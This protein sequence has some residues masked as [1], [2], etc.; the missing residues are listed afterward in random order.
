MI[1]TETH[2]QVTETDLQA[3]N[4]LTL[5][6]YA[7][8]E[9]FTFS[10]KF[11]D[12]EPTS[13]GRIWSK[14]W[15][16]ANVEHFVGLPVTLNHENNQNLVL[17]RVYSAEQKENAIYG[18]VYVPLDSPIG[19]ESKAKIENGLFKS[20]S[21]G[22]IAENQRPIGK[23]M[24]ILP[25][26]TDRLFELSFVAVPGCQTCSVSKESHESNEC[27]NKCDGSCKCGQTQKNGESA[28]Y[29]E[30][31]RDATPLL[32]F[33]NQQIEELKTEFVRLAGLSLNITNK[34]LLEN[35]ANQLDPLTLKRFSCGIRENSLVGKGIAEDNSTD[36]ANLKQIAEAFTNI[37]KTKGV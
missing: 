17:G 6:E 30:D 19:Q 22:A 9:V 14:E 28:I 33:A 8:D 15:Q 25:G 29:C 12:D 34:E 27:N 21:I 32:E 1:K 36:N 16:K 20:V 5:R 23:H 35:V 10:A 18:K 24:E 11:I 26:K 3:I 4:K 7:A 13:N 2:K 31:K 37:R